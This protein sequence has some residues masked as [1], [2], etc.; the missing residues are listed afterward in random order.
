MKHIGLQDAVFLYIQLNYLR[1]NEPRF[2]PTRFSCL[3]SAISY[4]QSPSI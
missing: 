4:A 1:K 3:A 2:P